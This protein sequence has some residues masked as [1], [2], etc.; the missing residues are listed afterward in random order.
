M[1]LDEREIK[2]RWLHQDAEHVKQNL[3]IVRVG[4]GVAYQKRSEQ[5]RF[6]VIFRRD[7][8]A[9]LE[10]QKPALGTPQPPQRLHDGIVFAEIIRIVFDQYLDNL[11]ALV[12]QFQSVQRH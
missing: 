8:F 5:V 4:L 9:V 6:F 1:V 3:D 7:G 12:L 11:K 10:S 2:R